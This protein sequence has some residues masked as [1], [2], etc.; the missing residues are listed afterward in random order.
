MSGALAGIAGAVEVMGIHHKFYDQFSPGYGFDSIAVAFLGSSTAVG[1]ALSALLFGAL[2]NGALGMQIVT[3]T[4]KEI[5][6]LIQAMVIIFAG[7]RF[8]R[9][10]QAPARTGSG[11]SA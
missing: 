2:R 7:M 9:P 8:L 10:T 11:D 6:T 1:T 3:D 5:V 4:P